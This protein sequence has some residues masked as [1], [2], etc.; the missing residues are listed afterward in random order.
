M[1]KKEPSRIKSY[2]QRIMP[3]IL[4]LNAVLGALFLDPR[5]IGTVQAIIMKT[6]STSD[7]TN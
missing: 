3:I 6:T 2:E 7:P 5:R 1:R 4:K